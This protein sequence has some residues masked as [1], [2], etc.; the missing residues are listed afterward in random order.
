MWS[1]PKPLKEGKVDEPIGVL[2]CPAVALP[3]SAKRDGLAGKRGGAL[4]N[5]GGGDVDIPK[6]GGGDM[7]GM[8]RRRAAPVTPAC[9]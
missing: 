2:N 7:A 1:P 5:G 4:P 8:P 9:V 6:G 3:C